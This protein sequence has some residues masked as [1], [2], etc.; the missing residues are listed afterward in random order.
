M[1]FPEKIE[2]L[3][4]AGEIFSR[5]L[6]AAPK[7]PICLCLA[8]LFDWHKGD[9]ANAEMYFLQ[10]LKTEQP[11][12][13]PLFQYMLFLDWCGLHSDASVIYECLPTLMTEPIYNP[14]SFSEVVG[15]VQILV[16]KGWT[17][18]LRLTATENVWDVCARIS[19]NLNI[20]FSSQSCLVMKMTPTVSG[21]EKLKQIGSDQK[22]EGS[23]RES[24]AFSDPRPQE[25]V[26][27]K[28]DF[29]LILI[30]R[31]PG[32]VFE[33]FDKDIWTDELLKE[34]FTKPIPRWAVPFPFLLYYSPLFP[35][36][37]PFLLF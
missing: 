34:A 5:L 6:E 16:P 18:T 4:E 1:I 12:G 13:Y 19:E 11:Q 32:I 2:G 27:D 26:L 36:P 25:R 23:L 14:L 35:L 22:R 37:P 33:F 10:S 9:L 3:F 15:M 8:A 30:Q 21:L 28:G 29:P 17:K 31:D 24:D 7:D 20:P